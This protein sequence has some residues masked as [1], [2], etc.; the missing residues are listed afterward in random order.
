VSYGRVGLVL[1]LAGAAYFGS[2]QQR[3]ERTDAFRAA[4]AYARSSGIAAGPDTPIRLGRFPTGRIDATSGKAVLGVGVLGEA[5]S[6]MD[7][8][9]TLVGGHWR[10]IGAALSAPSAA[11]VRVEDADRLRDGQRATARAHALYRNGRPDEA[12]EEFHAAL[13]ADPL[14]S[15]ARYWLGH[16]LEDIGDQEAA[17]ASFL[18]A[19][20]IT[21]GRP[22]IEYAVGV[23][24]GRV[25]DLERSLDHLDRAVELDGRSGLVY[26]GR[27][28]TRGRLGDAA[29]A[30]AD[31]DRACR[32]GYQDGCDALRRLR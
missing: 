31:L 30:S 20:E 7:L 8:E 22:H 24:Y 21:P 5:R 6:R 1:A 2:W 17:L 23:A 16:L 32:R 19:R 3:Y 29:G 4:A 11:T 14:N 15:E 28:V 27:A 12:L 10:V 9:L 13:A 25:G 26:F 18:T